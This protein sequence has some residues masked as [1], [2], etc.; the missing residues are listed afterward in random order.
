MW[1]NAPNFC[2]SRG[3]IMTQAVANIQKPELWSL[4]KFSDPTGQEKFFF[5]LPFGPTWE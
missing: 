5:G 1:I 3:G 2:E 4:G